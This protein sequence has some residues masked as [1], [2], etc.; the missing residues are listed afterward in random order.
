MAPEADDQIAIAI[1]LDTETPTRQWEGLKAGFKS[2]PIRPEVLPPD[3]GA[4]RG[5]RSLLDAYKEHRQELRAESGLVKTAARDFAAFGFEAKG[6]AGEITR[7]I[8]AFAFGGGF[9]AV[10]EVVKLTV[11]KLSELAARE[12]EAD[13]AAA[14]WIRESNAGITTL[15]GKVD[16][17]IFSLQGASRAMALAHTEMPPLLAAEAQATHELE[18]AKKKLAAVQ[19]KIA[20][21]DADA[22][23]SGTAP[24]G[25]DSSREE[26]EV[27]RLQAR[28]DQARA[29]VVAGQEQIRRATLAEGEKTAAAVGAQMDKAA[30]DRMQKRDA[31]ALAAADQ[32]RAHAA[33]MRALRAQLEEVG[34]EEVTKVRLEGDR[35]L[36]DLEDQRARARE[37][38]DVAEEARLGEK[39]YTQRILNAALLQQAENKAS[40]DRAAFAQRLIAEEEKVEEE[41]TRIALYYENLRATHGDA[42]AAKE[43]TDL[44]MAMAKELALFRGNEQMETTIQAA[45]AK[46]RKAILLATQG[47]QLQGARTFFSTMLELSRT[48][49]IEQSALGK[50]IA[51]TDAT[52]AGIVAVQR[53]LAGPPGPPWTFAIAAATGALAAANV[54][55]IAGIGG[56][57]G[58]EA[59]AVT[60]PSSQQSFGSGAQND[61]LGARGAGG[62]TTQPQ[63]IRETVI[64]VGSAFESPQETARRAARTI[65]LA[66]KLDLISRET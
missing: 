46:K 20:A 34:A 60:G 29:A 48:A 31:E 18:E 38:K 23:A 36:D 8:G 59:S 65:Q 11:V 32:D 17:L 16:E 4:E 41:R 13:E 64:L 39:I 2:N 43:L 19:D 1:R 10:A 26:A 9:G 51:I 24:L 42:R 12:R 52:I 63:V 22:L 61:S 3:P 49:G 5:M 50:A 21:Q 40:A 58:T 15:K 14:K 55:K 54:A 66:R 7:L 44:Q 56:G 45:E 28:L 37:V 57:G 62:S 27:R 33:A 53:A 47:D 35:T 6:T 25:G 30:A